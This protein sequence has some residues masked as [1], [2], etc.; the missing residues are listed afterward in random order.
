MIAILLMWFLLALLDA[1]YF[2]DT[3][4][5]TIIVMLRNAICIVTLLASIT[6]I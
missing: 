6:I 1:I 5:H 2:C 3:E 4:S